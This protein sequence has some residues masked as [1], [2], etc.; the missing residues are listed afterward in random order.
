M[1]ASRA[2]LMLISLMRPSRGLVTN[3]SLRR[4]ALRSATGPSV[5]ARPALLPPPPAHVRM[6]CAPPPVELDAEGQPLSKTA[7]KKRAKLA[8]QAARKAAQKAEKTA[9]A[10]ASGAPAPAAESAP[11]AAAEETPAPYSCTDAGVMMSDAS[12][13]LL[14]R[15]YVPI[16]ALGVGEYA[17]EAAGR[18]VWVRGRVARLRAG[19]SNCF[20]V[21]RA[22]GQ[23]TVQACFFKDKSRPAQ[24]AAMLAALGGLSEESIVDVR[25]VLSAADVKSCSQRS[26]EL[27]LVEVSVV[28]RAE[29][30]LPFQLD[31]AGRSEAEIEASL[32]SER[33]FPRIGQELRLD[34]RW[35]D[36]RVPA[37]HAVM[38][39]QAAVCALFREALTARGFVEIHTPKLIGG[40]S[41]GAAAVLRTDSARYH[42]PNMAGGAGVFRTDYFGTSACLAQSP[43]LYASR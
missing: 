21:L 24:S 7:L 2:S 3:P 18:E 34:H 9:A 41:E 22:Q 25:G 16:R 19:A 30:R 28:S 37:Q 20:V 26:V 15:V 42:L 10:A 29:P 38:R 6:L 43:Q 5:L 13:A 8:A 4:Q 35:L 11:E 14:D 32:G 39:T 12:S 31:D 33:P 23:Y 17:A 27:Q 36:L 1:L 40:E